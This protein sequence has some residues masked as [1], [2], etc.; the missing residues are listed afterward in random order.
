MRKKLLAGLLSLVMGFSFL[1]MGVIANAETLPEDNGNPIEVIEISNDEMAAEVIDEMAANVMERSYAGEAYTF[2]ERASVYSDSEDSESNTDPNYAYVVTNDIVMQ[3]AIETEN[4][5]RW[6]AFSLSERSKVCI[7]LQMVETMDADLYMFQLNEE[8]YDLELLGG[9]ANE[10]LGTSEYFNNVMD[11]GVYFFAVSGYEGTGAFAFAYYQSTADVAYEVNDTSSTA[12]TVAFN[13]NVIGVID[14]PYDIDYYKFTVTTPTI[15]QYSISS[16]NGYSLLYAGKSG[17]SSAIYTVNSSSKSYKIMPGT[18][19][20]A[21]LSESGS[22]SATSTYTVNFKKVGAMSGD[23]SVT[24][25]GISENAGIVYETN[26]TGSINYVN[27]NPVDI[28][29]SYYSNLSNSAG[30]QY[31]DISIDANAGACAILTDVY[32][33]A[34]VH[35]YSSTKPAMSVS[36]RPALMLTFYAD[37]NFYKIHCRGTGSYSMNTFWEDLNFVTVLIDPATGKLIDIVEYNYYYDFAPVGSNR[38]TL[39]RSYL[40]TFYNN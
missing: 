6:Y 14:S 21:V 17:S 26:N 25:V 36:S 34:A 18:Y 32:E 27:G 28:S 31:Y 8:T 30:S 19:Y 15:I 7:L 11:A 16:S 10:G 1:N 24:L 37:S 2:T 40:M 5:M 12:T 38:I 35:Y 20:F 9:S 4:E 39:T 3:G 29:Y 33:P 23:S 22:Y 13:S